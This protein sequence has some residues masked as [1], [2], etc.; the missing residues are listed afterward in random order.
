MISATPTPSGPLARTAAA[1]ARTTF[2]RVSC[3]WVS[4]YRMALRLYM[5][6]IILAL[7]RW[8]ARDD[9]R[10]DRRRSAPGEP[11]RPARPAQAADLRD[12]GVRPVHGPAGHPDRRRLAELHP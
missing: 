7:G 11:R 2:W 5:M 6:T 8:S 9:R 12:H 10:D 1:A 4:E 3:L